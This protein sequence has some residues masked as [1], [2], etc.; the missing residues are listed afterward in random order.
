MHDLGRTLQGTA[1]GIGVIMTW[2]L[3]ITMIS[4]GLKIGKSL[5]QLFAPRRM[6]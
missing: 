4:L 5:W 6:G 2:V 1:T 3:V